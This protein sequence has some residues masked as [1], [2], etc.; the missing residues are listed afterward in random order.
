MHGNIDDGLLIYLQRDASEDGR[1][2]TGHFH[3]KVIGPKWQAEKCIHAIG[4]ADD[5]VDYPSTDIGSP[6]TALSAL[7]A[8][9]R[10]SFYCNRFQ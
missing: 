3:L 6:T 7:I 10:I 1:S 4:I 9:F 2:E 5:L 8:N